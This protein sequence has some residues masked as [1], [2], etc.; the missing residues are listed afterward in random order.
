MTALDDRL[1]R[2]LDEVDA[3]R[4]AGNTVADL[5]RALSTV[6]DGL[7][8]HEAID[9]EYQE[10]SDN[11]HDAAHFRLTSLESHA[12][13]PVRPELDSSHNLGEFA[14]QVEQ[15]AI[16]GYRRQDA[17]PEELVSKVVEEAEARRAQVKE[18]AR[19]QKAEADSIA[20]RAREAS[21][22]AE[23]KRGRAKFMRNLAL[24]AAGG[25][26]ALTGLIESIRALVHH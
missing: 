12:A 14:R 22:K 8:K 18:L 21:E 26:G 1:A 25:G 15:A 16:E 5:R 23:A 4:S 20:E 6:V 10:N 13:A 11:R 2:Y 19:L 17:T 7:A 9:L 3:N 24:A